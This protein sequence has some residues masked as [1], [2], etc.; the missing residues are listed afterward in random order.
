MATRK[1]F[2]TYTEQGVTSNFS[3]SRNTLYSNFHSVID[4]ATRGNVLLGTAEFLIL[5]EK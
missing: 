1:V 5:Q 3:K 4:S 2:F